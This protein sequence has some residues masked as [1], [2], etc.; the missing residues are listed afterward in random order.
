MRQVDNPCNVMFTS[1]SC[2]IRINHGGPHVCDCGGSWDD[3][4]NI[5]RMPKGLDPMETLLDFMFL[6]IDEDD[7]E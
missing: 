7:H 1:C 6:S 3:Q 5:I 2:I 4:E